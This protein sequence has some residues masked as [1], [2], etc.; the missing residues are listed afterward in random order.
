M[1]ILT[2]IPGWDELKSINHLRIEYTGDLNAHTGGIQ[3]EVK[4]T[5]IL[6]LPPR[7]D[8]VSIPSWE[9]QMVAGILGNSFESIKQL[10][11]EQCSEIT[12][13]LTLSS[14]TTRVNTGSAS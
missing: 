2:L 14:S 6:L 4:V 1:T 9:I 11:D 8:R 3:E 13:H 12:H 5:Q 10:Q 7:D